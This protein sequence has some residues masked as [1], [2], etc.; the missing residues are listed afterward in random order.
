MDLKTSPKF[1]VQHSS[2]TKLHISFQY[3]II[4]F[5]SNFRVFRSR[6]FDMIWMPFLKIIFGFSFSS[7]L[8]STTKI[9]EQNLNHFSL[10]ETWFSY[11]SILIHDSPQKNKIEHKREER[12]H[13]MN[14]S[15]WVVCIIVNEVFPKTQ[16][17]IF[18]LTFKT[19]FRYDRGFFE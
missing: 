16:I 2:Y 3:S 19:R 12:K 18:R 1:W 8:F 6:N 17:Q 7:K 10:T 9:S 11:I 5:W 13:K 15:S 4:Q 14:L